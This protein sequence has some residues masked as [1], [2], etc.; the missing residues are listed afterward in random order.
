MKELG[1]GFVCRACGEFHDTLPLSFSVKAPMA[2][3]AV[4]AAEL[5]RRVVLTRDQCVIDGTTFYLRGRIVVPILDL[6]EPFVWGVWAEVSPK[7][8]IRTHNLWTTVGREL[9]PPYEGWLDTNLP[10][11][12]TTVNLPVLIQTQPVGRRPHFTILSTEHPLGNEQ[13]C[14]IARSRVE[15]IAATFLHPNELP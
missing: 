2:A 9:E 13:Q 8:F 1:I 6:D 11:Y 7:N 14:G 10:L 3:A 15:E 4:P 12:G 5:G